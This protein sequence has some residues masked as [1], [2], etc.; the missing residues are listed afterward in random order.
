MSDNPQ[1][2]FGRLGLIIRL[3]EE[4]GCTWEEAAAALRESEPQ[5]PPPAIYLSPGTRTLQ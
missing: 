5:E 4:C 2:L 3:C 1:G